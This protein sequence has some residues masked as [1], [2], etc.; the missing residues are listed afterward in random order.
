VLATIAILSETILESS[1]TIQI[2]FVQR[3]QHIIIQKYYTREMKKKDF[4]P[5]AYMHACLCR[6]ETKF[7][8]ANLIADSMEIAHSCYT[9]LEYCFPVLVTT[10]SALPAPRR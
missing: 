8:S 4:D 7:S 6:T 10:I 9:I 5:H 3:R 1:E 2:K